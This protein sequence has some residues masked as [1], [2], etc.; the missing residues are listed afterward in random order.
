M[1]ILDVNTKS[2]GQPPQKGER[3]EVGKPSLVKMGAGEDV[4]AMHVQAQGGA[5]G[6]YIEL[7]HSDLAA[8]PAIRLPVSIQKSKH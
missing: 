6:R 8:M 5:S 7:V 1:Q 3:V 4:I 2:N